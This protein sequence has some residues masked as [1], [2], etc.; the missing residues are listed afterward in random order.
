[1]QLLYKFSIVDFIETM[2]LL[3]FW[4]NWAS[5]CGVI[6]GRNSKRRWWSGDRRRG[7]GQTCM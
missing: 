5:S 7:G 3:N 2:L 4:I 1:M 6:R